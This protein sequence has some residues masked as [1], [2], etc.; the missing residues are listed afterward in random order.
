[1]K[2]QMPAIRALMARRILVNYRVDPQ[3][4]ARLVPRPFRV[5][6]IHCWGV[7]GICLVRLRRSRPRGFPAALGQTS[8]NAAYRIAAEWDEAG[9][10]KEGVYIPLRHTNSRINAL[11]GGRVFPGVHALSQFLVR[12]ADKLFKIELRT[13]NQ[14]QDL[15]LLCRETNEWPQDSV[16]ASPRKASWFF[17]NSCVGY[18]ATRDASVHEGLQLSPFAW[19]ASPL[20]IEYI[21]APFFENSVVFPQGSIHLDSATLMRD[22]DHEWRVLPPL[23]SSSATQST[24]DLLTKT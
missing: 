4:L 24:A 17:R 7:A 15:K 9:R 14:A 16:F 6:R 18:S 1:M 8:E 20:H 3:V 10:T 5:K 11:A 21:N 12:E 13:A 23:S 19:N 2:L 22:I